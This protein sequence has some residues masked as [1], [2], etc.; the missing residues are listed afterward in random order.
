MEDLFGVKMDYIMLVLLAVLLPSLVAIGVMALRNRIMLKMALRNI[1]RRKSQTALIVVGIMISTLIMAASFGTGDTLSFSI[2]KAVV[3]GLGTI[4]EIIIPVRSS[5]EEELGAAPYVPID[6]FTQ[7]QQELS[8]LDSIDGLAPGVGESV[9]SFN[10]RTGQ[11][12]GDLRIAGVDPGTLQGFGGFKLANG[13]DMDLSAL[14]PNEAYINDAAA[15]ELD[16]VPGDEVS[17]F[18]MGTPTSFVIKDVVIAGGLAGSDPTLLVSL[19]RAQQVLDREGYINSIV[20][21]N[22]GDQYSGAEHSEEVTTALRV[23]FTDREVAAQL[24][25]ALSD[26]AVLSSLEEREARARPERQEDLASLRAELAQLELSDELVSLLADDDIRGHILSALEDSGQ[27]ETI[28]EVSTLFESLAEFRVLDVKRQF[29]EQADQIGSA[30]TSLFIMMG[31]FSIMVGILLIFLIFVMLAA[32]RRSEMGMARAVGARRIHLV[33]MF[34]FEG[35]AYSLMSGAVGVVLGLLASAL[36]VAIVNRIFAGGSVA[37][38]DEFQLTRHFE[39]RSI[40]VAYCLGMVISLATVGVSAYQVSRMNIVAAVRNLR[41]PREVNVST[42]RQLL[43]GPFLALSRPFVLLYSMLRALV[44]GRVVDSAGLLGQLAL[45][46]LSA[47]ARF[48]MAVYS[49]LARPFSQG[50]LAILI[51]AVIV[52][53]GTATDLAM[54]YRIGF[55]VFLIGV[56]LTVRTLMRRTGVRPEVADRV[57]YTFFGVVGLAYWFVP[58]SV[59]QNVTGELR[60]GVEMFF[61]SGVTM[62]ALAV[63]TVMYN[64]DVLMKILTILTSRFGGFRPVL[65]TAVAYPMSAKFRTGLTLAMFALVIFTLIVMSILT[66]AFGGSNEQIEAATGGWDIRTQANIRN[67]IGDLTAAIEGEPT[68]DSADFEAIGGYTYL[69][70]QAR[71][72]GAEERRWRFYAVRAADDEL[73]SNLEDGV[74]L[75]A[76]GYGETSEDV[77][78]ALRE[79]DRLAV[80]EALVVPT[81]DGGFEERIFPFEL[82]GFYYDDDTMQPI[83]VEVREPRTGEVV[84]VTIIGVLDRSA[85][86]FGQLGGGMYISRAGLDSAI[87]FEIPSTTYNIRVAEGVDPIETASQ[88]DAAFPEYGLESRSLVEIAEESVAANKAFNYL[89]TGFMALGLMVGVASLGVISLRAVV[90]RRQQIGVLRAIGYRRGLIQLSFL[91]ESSFIVLL[92]V[93]IGIGLGA[94]ISYNIVQEIQRDVDTIRFDIPWIQIIVIIAI[95]YLFSLATTFLPAR[96]AS[97]IYPAEALRYE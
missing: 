64:A 1:P 45:S 62:V 42:T 46:P 78:E 92:G 2:R 79:N 36:I 52:W 16:A 97:N 58:F 53:N 56:G 27:V 5:G 4:D 9:P 75:I 70:V 13:G 57:G 39:A 73:L 44:A 88:L 47:T 17:L 43:L 94:I 81:R 48:V 8:G 23:Q 69:P 55:T 7:L 63:W 28:R 86:L 20:V 22:L 24:H 29:I 72:I 60:G 54:S 41:P 91:T 85:D 6:R 82:E 33:Q 83:E 59:L 15:D 37:G 87:P 95:A 50:W 34:V 96:Q 31:L 74:H 40:V 71:Q 49:L 65:V 93:A 18:V 51:G 3:D 26:P 67:P 21:S 32:A 66:E 30:V 77:W 12:A 11:S 35:T 14:E 76:E 89:F 38:A 68:L 90:E 10:A 25:A 84:T 19:G 80:V 61:I